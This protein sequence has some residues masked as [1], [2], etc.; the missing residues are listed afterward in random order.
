MTREGVMIVLYDL[1]MVD[2]S[3]RKVYE[4]FR[5]E[6]KK[7]A[8]RQLQESVYVKHLRNVG[9]RDDELKRLNQIAPKSGNLLAFS[10]TMAQYKEIR[11]L[12]GEGIPFDYQF[13]SVVKM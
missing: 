13:S 3:S 7:L 12:R 4:K 1:P 8:Y 9:Y 5:S 2:K 6:L 11:V 10:L